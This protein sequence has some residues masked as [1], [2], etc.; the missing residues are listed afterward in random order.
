MLEKCRLS[1]DGQGREATEAD[2]RLR[3]SEERLRIALEVGHLAT[4][5]W[6]ITTE[7]VSWSTEH[8]RMMGYKIGEITPCFESWAKRVHPE[9]LQATVKAL[10]VA[11]DTNTTYAHTYRSLHP[12]GSIIWLSAVGR[13]FYDK[14]LHPIRM[15]GVMQDVTEQRRLAEQQRVL[16]AELQHRTRNLMAV[17]QSTAES[18]IKSCHTLG[19]FKQ[20]FRERLATLSRV[21]GLLSRFDQGRDVEFQELLKTEL[22]AHAAFQEDSARVTFDGPDGVKLPSSTIQMLAMVLQE[23]ATNALKYGAMAQPGG[24]LAITW[25][26][27]RKTQ[28]H[29]L[30]IDWRECGV[31]IP[32][33]G[34]MPRGSGQGRILIE[35]SLPYQLNAVTTYVFEADGVHCTIELPLKSQE[36]AGSA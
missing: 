14:N 2:D 15:I 11:R 35:R 4:W 21:Q 10:E 36:E 23:L 29:R 33:Q 7:E 19:Q 9:D 3:T 6:N 25:S 18:T 12:D 31:T 30:H 1:T 28:P 16:V 26:L 34:A 17:V 5:D 32:A 22:F 24:K 8:F 20:N 13:Y 27:D